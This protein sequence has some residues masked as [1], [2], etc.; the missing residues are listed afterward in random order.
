MWVPSLPRT[1]SGVQATASGD[2][3]LRA[4]HDTSDSGYYFRG[5]IITRPT[6]H[7]RNITIIKMTSYRFPSVSPTQCK[8]SILLCILSKDNVHKCIQYNHDYPTTG[9]N[10]SI[11]SGVTLFQ[12]FRNTRVQEYR[13]SGVPNIW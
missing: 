10:R 6:R 12:G 8:L 13:S 3:S 5:F 9:I 4:P 7:F 2:L 1:S 11:I